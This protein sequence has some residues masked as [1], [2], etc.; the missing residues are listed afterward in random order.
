MSLAGLL[1]DGER[2]ADDIAEILQSVQETYFSE[3][4]SEIEVSNIA[5]YI[6][7]QE[8]CSFE[9]RE[10]PS[11]SVGTIVFRTE[12]AMLEYQKK[13]RKSLFLSPRDLRKQEQE[14]GARDQ[15]IEGLLPV[16]GVNVAVGDSNIGKSPAVV[17][18]G[19]CVAAGLPFLGRA[20]KQGKVV[21]LDF[22]NVGLLSD[23][24]EQTTKAVGADPTVVDSNLAIIDRDQIFDLDEIVK[25]TAD[26]ALVIVDSFRFLTNGDEKNGN[27]VMPI[28]SKLGNEKNCWLLVHHIRKGEAQQKDEAERDTSLVKADSVIQWLER[29][30]GH[31]SI[32]NQATNRWAMDDRGIK[33][34]LLIRV[35]VKGRAEGAPIHLNRIFEEET[36]IGYEVATGAGLLTPTQQKFFAEVMG[37][38]V[39]FADVVK[40]C[41]GNKSTASRLL[42]SCKEYKLVRELDGKRYEFARSAE[43]PGW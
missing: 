26:A 11:F 35:S 37:K 6:S 14:S 9:P 18:A 28:L 24:I 10:L 38:T 34:D 23:M 5:N 42:A 31:R 22:E 8:P 33:T 19:V 39:K 17:Q 1:H 3:S 7:R 4:K 41:A 15:L 30:S 2:S 29:A 16:R 27:V 20:T 36:P 43:V 21:L 32:I 13:K 40:V 25:A 12:A